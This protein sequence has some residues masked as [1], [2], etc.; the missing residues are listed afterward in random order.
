[1]FSS[2]CLFTSFRLTSP[3]YVYG[4]HLLLTDNRAGLSAPSLGGEWAGGPP[5]QPIRGSGG[6]PTET[7]F[8]KI[9]MLLPRDMRAE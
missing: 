9:R 5:P 7:E 4:R 2:A 8:C 3:F 6:A 1:M